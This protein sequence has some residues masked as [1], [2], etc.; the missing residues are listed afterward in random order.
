M[1]IKNALCKSAKSHLIYMALGV[2]S[3]ILLLN[4]VVLH[5]GI[6]FSLATVTMLVIVCIY[7]LKRV[8]L[9]AIIVYGIAV[10]FSPMTLP[11]ALIY[12]MAI[13]FI[14]LK[15]RKSPNKFI[16]HMLL[17][18][19]LAGGPLMF[20]FF[21]ITN[22]VIDQSTVFYVLKEITVALV[23]SLLVDILFTYTSLKKISN[24]SKGTS[25][26][27]RFSSI[28][29][30]TT[31]AA[32]T[33]PYL[34]FVILVGYNNV[35]NVTAVTDNALSS[36]LQ[37]VES[38]L[39]SL[40]PQEL[41][42][43]K[44][45]GAIQEIS[46]M[47]ELNNISAESGS[48]IVV[49][50][51]NDIVLGSNSDIS[52][53][54]PFIWR[55]GGAVSAQS[56]HSYYWVPNGE[57]STRLERWKYA[58]IIKERELTDVNLK[59][60]VMTPFTPILSN[61]LS[62][63]TSQLWVYLFFCSGMVLITL[64]F[65]RIFF[66]QL[67]K[68][69]DTT[70][71]IPSRLADGNNIE[72][73]KSNILE[74]DSLTD[75]FKIVADNLKKMFVRTHRLAYYDLLTGLPNRVSMQ[76]TLADYFNDESKNKAFAL[77]F[78]DLDRFKQVNDSLG[79]VVGDRLLQEIAERLT[80]LQAE[81]IKVFRV[82]GDEF[83]VIARKITKKS[84][85]G[86]AQKILK[87][88]NQPVCF[89]HHELHIT[90]SI[91]IAMYPQ[92]G[93]NVE[94]LMKLA[95][96]SMYVAKECGGNTY[97]F[98]TESLK[99]KLFEQMWFENQLRKVL[100]ANQFELYFQPIVDGITSEI[101]GMEALIRWKHLK[102]GFISPEQF[103]PIAEQSGLIIPIGQW[104]L[105]EACRQNKKWQDEGF[106]KV[107]VAVNLSARQFYN[108]NIVEEIKMILEETGLEPQYLELEITEGFMIKDPEYVS[109]ILNHLKEMG[110]TISI[111]DFGTGYSSLGQLKFFPVNV[112]KIDKSFVKNV[113]V[114]LNNKSIVKSIIN[115]AHGM[116]L[117][118]I[119]EGIEKQEEGD[120]LRKYNCDEMQG[121]YFARPVSG[122]KFTEIWRKWTGDLSKTE[123]L[124]S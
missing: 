73:Q 12:A 3:L 31:L 9:T 120:F 74:I 105:K 2:I 96:A 26:S 91:G 50:N 59:T 86:I 64:M 20:L 54:Q 30:H 40:T 115:L 112:V 38:Y 13:I 6:S 72:W 32:V 52:K 89:D 37:M 93:D 121:Y 117:K 118:V 10:L 78:F 90:S 88:I 33:I 84:V 36:Q 4:P 101:K 7:S 70:T 29:I 43:L 69:A 77:L 62:S 58:Y 106:T 61:I 103:I 16:H 47:R 55:L 23:S 15:R 45:H 107:R 19:L 49:L 63:Y 24:N 71:G 60:V 99:C 85:E 39:D 109:N 79:H 82:S 1:P 44:E 5:A 114:D 28:M 76:D 53:E 48:E 83:V 21:S 122:Q 18:W 100:D 97:V 98:Y 57:F 11:I 35:K 17:F 124:G 81:N 104:V 65:N 42:A 25:N 22:E 51:Q 75:N 68:L 41:F 27:L 123:R 80:K 46:L 94:T 95:D 67:A 66:R 87:L 116:N 108:K 14:S 113:E 56:D 8:I 110:V 119:A 102:K 92:H 34:I 111:D